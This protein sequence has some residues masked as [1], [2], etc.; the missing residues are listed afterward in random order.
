MIDEFTKNVNF[1]YKF[2]SL[3]HKLWYKIYILRWNIIII[4][5][6]SSIGP[7]GKAKLFINCF[8]NS[9]GTCATEKENTTQ[10]SNQHYIAPLKPSRVPVSNKM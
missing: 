5:K 1:F 3:F 6:T 8:R 9:T 2:T 10:V 4:I 7:N